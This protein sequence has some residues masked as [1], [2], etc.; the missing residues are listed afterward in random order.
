LDKTIAL[1]E[2]RITAWLNKIHTIMRTEMD[3]PKEGDGRLKQEE[4]LSPGL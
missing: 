1:V 4:C 3:A 2:W